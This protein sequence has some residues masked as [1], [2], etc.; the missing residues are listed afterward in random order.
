MDWNPLIIRYLVGIFLTLAPT[1][2]AAE[3]PPYTAYFNPEQGFK[4]AQRSF[5]GIFLQMAGGLEH[6]STPSNYLRHVAKE[7]KRV[8]AAWLTAK[9]KPANFRPAYFTDEYVE[10]LIA[11]WNQIAPILALESFSRNS[12]CHMRYAILG[13]WNV[14][15]DELAAMEPKLTDSQARAYGGFLAKVAFDKSDLASLDVFYSK[16]GGRD[17]LSD[18]GKGEMSKRVWRGLLPPEERE[19]DIRSCQG[20]TSALATLR[21]HQ[22]KTLASIEGTGK[23]ITAVELRQALISGLKLDEKTPAVAKL[24]SSERDALTYSHSIKAALQRRLDEISKQ[25]TPQQM[26]DINTAMDL[27]LD[28]L[29]VAAQLEFEAG[30]RDEFLRH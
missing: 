4:P 13:S 24:P 23:T 7:A 27:I 15:P 10:K 26:K 22:Q 8:E 29:L 6:C 30:V 12:G 28:G 14:P 25:A 19:A 11:G 1:L 21:E 3:S 9:G 2:A 20:G 17:L 16:D 5:Q 18:T